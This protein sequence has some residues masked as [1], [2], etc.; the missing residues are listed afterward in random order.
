MISNAILGWLKTQPATVRRHFAASSGLTVGMV[1]V[2]CAAPSPSR[3]VRTAS[4]KKA[5]A[6]SIADIPPPLLEWLASQGPQVRK[7]FAE[8]LGILG[9]DLEEAINAQNEQTPA[10]EKA[11]SRRRATAGGLRGAE[12]EEYER[13]MVKASA[14][15]LKA[16]VVAKRTEA[17]VAFSHKGRA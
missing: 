2:M 1:D 10:D 6:P 11:S 4:P 3:R 13:A 16:G 17:G 9:A 7:T 14:V 8:S 12:L 5:A 15:D